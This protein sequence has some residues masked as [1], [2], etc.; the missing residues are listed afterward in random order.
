[1][2][3]RD[4]LATDYWKQ[5]AK[6]VKE[7]DGYKCRI[8]NS[9]QQL[10]VHH[11]SYAHRGCDHLHLDELTTLCRTCHHR[12]HF[13]QKQVETKVIVK[14][15]V[16]YRNPP[17]DRSD[18]S[19]WNILTTEERGFYKK[20]AKRLKESKF[21]LARM[22]RIAVYD[23]LDKKIRQPPANS[24]ISAIKSG[25]PEPIRQPNGSILVGDLATV[26]ADMPPGDQIIL[27]HAILDKCRANGSFTTAT[28]K[29]FGLDSSKL[30][31]GWTKTLIGKTYSRATILEAMS[32]RHFYSPKTFKKR[33]KLARLLAQGAA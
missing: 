8:C 29:A 12:H 20:A 25:Q 3:Y 16:K 18:E 28:V 1:M 10:D 32:G 31:P 19:Y 5:V 15:V 33:R 2:P 7:R 21:K 17:Q 24:T 6:L 27:T 22:G 23:L 30:T 4:F 13:P 9:G 11:R 14:T 26:E